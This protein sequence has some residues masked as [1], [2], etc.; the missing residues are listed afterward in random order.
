MLPPVHINRGAEPRPSRSQQLW[1]A[2]Y[3]SLI[4]EEGTRELVRSYL[5]IL[6]EVLGTDPDV[7][8][9]ADVLANLNDPTK[10]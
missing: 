10:R 6:M 8:S 1:N 4:E 3:D 7:V 5:K 2:A 9:D